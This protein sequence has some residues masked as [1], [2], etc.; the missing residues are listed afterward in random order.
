MEAVTRIAWI[1]ITM[2]LLLVQSVPVYPGDAKIQWVTAERLKATMQEREG[3]WLVDIR[4]A[5]SY[6]I[7]HIEGAVNIGSSFVLHKNLPK[8][9]PL[10]LIDDTLGLLAAQETAVEL[11]KNGYSQVYLLEGGMNA[12]R[13][14]GNPVAGGKTG[15]VRGVTGNELQKALSNKVPLRIYDLS[16]DKERGKGVLPGSKT[17]SGKDAGERLDRLKEVLL[18]EDK[19]GPLA[20]L[21]KEEPVVL[22]FSASEDAPGLCEKTFHGIKGDVRYLIGGYEAFTAP[23]SGRA[24]GI[25]LTCPPK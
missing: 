10:I 6:N 22:V 5:G 1:A 8:D 21:T 2:A 9:K 4:S 12:W 20:G 15:V 19:R 11:L 14:D 13:R 3:L 23:R 25:C 7:G 18:K 16:G 24:A 17:V